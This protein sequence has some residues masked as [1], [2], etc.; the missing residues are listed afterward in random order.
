M[1]SIVIVQT[2]NR[3]NME[4]VKKNTVYYNPDTVQQMTWYEGYSTLVQR[5]PFSKC[6]W[7]GY[8]LGCPKDHPI[9]NV[10]QAIWF[11]QL[12]RN[13]Y[14]TSVW[15]PSTVS[16]SDFTN[17]LM[18]SRFSSRSKNSLK[19]R[20]FQNLLEDMDTRSKYVDIFY[21]HSTNYWW[22]H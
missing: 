5:T 18:G 13:F 17:L 14:M 6:C 12:L 10:I 22:F 4:Y 3:D 19:C 8:F 21:K 2:T 15:M 16:F 11:N 7:A 9:K 1:F 20:T